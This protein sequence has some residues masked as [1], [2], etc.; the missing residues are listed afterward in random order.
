M[1]ALYSTV[2]G[3]L[4]VISRAYPR[5]FS[6]A[7]HIHAHAHAHTHTH[8]VTF[9]IILPTS[10]REKREERREGWGWEGMGEKERGGKIWSN[11]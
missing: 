11:S 6:P 4:A 10:Y 7:L 8:N 9:P 1:G 3:L 5:F 2:S